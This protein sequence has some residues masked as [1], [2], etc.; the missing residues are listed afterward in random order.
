MSDVPGLYSFQWSWQ[1]KSE[2]PEDAITNTYHFQNTDTVTDYDN[3]RDMLE[4]FYTVQ[5][6]DSPSTIVSF[7]SP[8][9]ITGRWTL[10]AYALEDP[11]PRQPV[12]TWQ[13]EATPISSTP[14]PA[15]VALVQSFQ[16]DIESG[17][18]PARRRN[19]VY[20]GPFGVSSNSSTGRPID[21]L[22]A[23]MLFQGKQLIL[24]SQASLRWTWVAYSP[25]ADQANA[26][27]NGWVDNA[28]D[29]QRR[30]GLYYNQRGT[31]SAT[32]PE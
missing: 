11:K 21:N 14:L 6:P 7:M 10:K 32:T 22:V 18:I 23:T 24:E 19:R 9:S 1:A 4:N 28:W 5:A 26:I 27:T 2:R 30:R 12:I 13:G 8:Q 29:T 20:L 15:E 3:V 16:A 25:T 17:E 31:Y